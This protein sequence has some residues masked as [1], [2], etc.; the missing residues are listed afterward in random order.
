MPFSLWDRNQL[1][2]SVCTCALAF[3]GL[4][5]G[6]SDRFFSDRAVVILQI[7]WLYPA[8]GLGDTEGP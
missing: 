7:T 6:P 3:L 5:M 2:I 8:L 1:G 4:P